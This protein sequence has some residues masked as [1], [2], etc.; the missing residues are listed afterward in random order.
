MV[1]AILADQKTQ[2]RRVVKGM[3][4]QPAANCHPHIIQKH[5]APYFDAYCSQQKT[6]ANPRG[7]GLDWC[8]WQVDDR[9][10]L[11]TIRCPYGQPGDRLWVR[12]THF[13][14]AGILNVTG[15]PVYF[16]ADGDLV[17]DD[18]GE[19][20]GWWFG[21]HF[22][23][24]ASK[25]FR[26]TPAIHMPRRLSRILLEITDVRVELTQNI[27]DADIL[28]EGIRI[29]TTD[30]G[31]PTI[32]LLDGS[33]RFLPRGFLD[34]YDPTVHLRALW[35]SLWESIHGDGAKDRPTWVWVV[36]FRRLPNPDADRAASAAPDQRVVG[37]SEN[38]NREN[39]G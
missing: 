12:E 14:A 9:V 20:D 23:P 37:H 36:S 15:A 2:T 34:A 31:R 22:F 24:G 26:W 38:N 32:S 30:A 11:P 16:R 8:W 27:S 1:R 18:S 19:R 39:Q 21:D 10:C 5:H 17:R 29:P 6:V 35:W 25:P 28:A 33:T 13:A 7:I 3:P 4:P